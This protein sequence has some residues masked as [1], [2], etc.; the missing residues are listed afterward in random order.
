MRITNVTVS[1]QGSE[2]LLKNFQVEYERTYFG[3]VTN[4]TLI[5]IIA[6]LALY[7]KAI[8][9]RFLLSNKRLVFLPENSRL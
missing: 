2:V 9:I 6:L 3:S 7:F 8:I 1:L 5:S 4:M